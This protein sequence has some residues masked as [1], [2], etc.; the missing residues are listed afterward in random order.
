M[1]QTNNSV[2][3][4]LHRLSTW[5]CP[6]LLLSAGAWCTAPAAV[7]RYLLPSAQQQTRRTSLLLSIDGT[8][9]RTLDT[10]IDLSPHA[11]RTASI[12][13][14]GWDWKNENLAVN[15]ETSNIVKRL[16]IRRWHRCRLMHAKKI[17]ILWDL[18]FWAQRVCIW[19]RPGPVKTYVFNDN[20]WVFRF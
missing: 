15:G 2:F 14:C 16:K 18:S 8:D 5:R 6:H 7:Y 12:T 4:F 10:Y 17:P 9:R 1:S 13:V 19:F 3:S 20:T 11:M